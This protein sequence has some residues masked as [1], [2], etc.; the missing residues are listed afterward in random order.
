MI[1]KD[2]I[3]GIFRFVGY[4]IGVAMVSR[5][6]K[7]FQDYFTSIIIQKVGAKLYADGLKHSLELPLSSF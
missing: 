6:A 7:N 4:A 3:A 5:I 2:I 1:A